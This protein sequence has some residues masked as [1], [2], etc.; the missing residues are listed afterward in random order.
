MSVVCV[1]KLLFSE[2]QAILKLSVAELS[3]EI[4]KSLA[5]KLD[6]KEFKAIAAKDNTRAALPQRKVQSEN[7]IVCHI[8]YI[9]CIM[10][11]TYAIECGST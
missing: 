9:T 5:K 4:A 2:K 10:Y 7:C 1:Y 6:R 11:S 3:D 8:E